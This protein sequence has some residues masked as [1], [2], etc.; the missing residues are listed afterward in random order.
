MHEF[1][2]NKSKQDFTLFLK[3]KKNTQTQNLCLPWSQQSSTVTKALRR[4]SVQAVRL[5]SAR[6]IGEDKSPLRACRD[7]ATVNGNCPSCNFTAVSLSTPIIRYKIVGRT[8]TLPVKQ[9]NL[10]SQ[11]FKKSGMFYIRKR[12]SF[13]RFSFLFITYLF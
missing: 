4:R 1:N 7:A 13:L 10:M 2:L 9:S 6:A 8:E 11:K 12:K 5:F 3:K